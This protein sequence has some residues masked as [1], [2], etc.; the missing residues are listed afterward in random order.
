MPVLARRI[1]LE[2]LVEA[3]KRYGRK[4]ILKGL[5]PDKRKAHYVGLKN[6]KKTGQMYYVG[7]NT[8]KG[9]VPLYIEKK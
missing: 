1:K 5:F 7:Y 3:I 4:Y 8:Y 2:Y 9:L 6:K